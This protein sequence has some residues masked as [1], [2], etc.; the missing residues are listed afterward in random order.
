MKSVLRR[1][2]SVLCA[3]ALAVSCVSFSAF[4]A[5]N[6]ALTGTVFV[7]SIHSSNGWEPSSM[8]NGSTA[9]T[10][11]QSGVDVGD[12]TTAYLGVAWALAQ[13]F[14]TVKAYW[15]A[16]YPGTDSE[17][18]IAESAAALAEMSQTKYT[19]TCYTEGTTV[20]TKVTPEFARADGTDGVEKVDTWTF[21][22]P[23][24]AYAVKILCKS[25]G[26]GTNKN[27]SCWELEVF[28]YSSG[29]PYDVTGLSKAKSYVDKAF[30]ATNIYGY[31]SASWSNYTTA[32]TNAT[33]AITACSGQTV[34]DVTD[35]P[36]QDAL[37]AVTTALYEA[38]ACLTGD[39]TPAESANVLLNGIMIYDADDMLNYASGNNFR[40][41]TDGLYAND[42]NCWQPDTGSDHKYLYL[43]L[44][45]PADIETVAMYTESTGEVYSIEVTSTDVTE[46]TD[47]AGMDALE[48][49]D[50]NAVCD[51]SI[52]L[53]NSTS[54][55]LYKLPTAAEAT[56]IRVTCT[57]T[58]GAWCKLREVEAYGPSAAAG[59][60]SAIIEATNGTDYLVA[61]N[62]ASTE[63]PDNK[64]VKLSLY[65][66]RNS[67][68]EVAET[69]VYITEAYRA[70][71][72]GDDVFSARDFSGAQID[73][74]LVGV[75]LTNADSVSSVAVKS[76]D[77]VD[78]IV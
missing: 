78:P 69:E 17:I 21:E 27:M 52:S 54:Y 5:D 35:Y 20:W 12:G 50:T 24:T 23:V 45:N 64:I 6:L 67:D 66:Y 3:L 63:V 4:A 10:R 39:G 25:V 59:S 41:L 18:Y 28:D 9:S 61:V 72:L 7:D 43:K 77:F 32:Y 13:T 65:I 51:L 19:E 36:D 71:V 29:S 15:E 74:Y 57:T 58:N 33:N 60:G 40:T 70:I 44:N 37:D 76:V 8:I 62:I 68:T 38:A 47:M 46:I 11:W 53:G 48:W 1:S 22:S 55:Q 34:G 42:S 2:V 49:I 73:D 26:N 31:S 56:A 75:R 14:D 16:S 30:G